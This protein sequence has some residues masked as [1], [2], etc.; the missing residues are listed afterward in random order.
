MKKMKIKIILNNNNFFHLYYINQFKIS[1]K[2]YK[3]NKLNNKFYKQKKNHL[4]TKI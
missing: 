4:M 2:I 1:I 3:I